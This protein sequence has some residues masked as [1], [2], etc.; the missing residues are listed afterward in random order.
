M[1]SKL[2]LTTALFILFM[3]VS[4]QDLVQTVRGTVVDKISSTPLAGAVVVAVNT[5]PLLGANS[6]MEGQFR[7]ANVPVGIQNFHIS[8]LGYKDVVL[9]EIMVSSGKELVLNVQME[10]DITQS[11]EVVIKADEIKNKPLNAMTSVSARTFSV[12]EAQKF[13]AAVNDPGRMVTSFAGVVSSDDG[14]N[15]VS[16][17]GNSPSGLQWK[18]EGVEIPNPNHYAQAASS[19]GGISILSAQ[20]LANSDFMTGAFAAEYGNA[21]SGVF[22]L[23]LRKGNNEKREYTFQAGLLG[24][25]AAIEGPFSKKGKGSYLV[26]YRYSTLSV[27]QNLGISIGD[28]VTNFQDISFNFH[29]PSEKAGSFSVFG[30]GGLSDQYENASKDTSTW[31]ID[32]KQFN[33]NYYSNT[34][35]IGLKHFI[36]LSD[37]TYIQSAVTLG[38]HN[39]GYKSDKLDEDFTPQFAYNENYLN[40]RLQFTTVL[41]HKLNAKSSFRSGIYY[42]QLMY[43]LGLKFKEEDTGKIVAPI[44]SK[45]S[46]GLLQAFGQ[47]KYR[48]NERLT[49]NAGLHSMFLHSNASKSVEPRLGMRYELDEKQTISFGYGLHSQLLPL[50]LLLSYVD[51]N[52]GQR[53]QPNKNLGFNKAHHFVVA[54]ERNLTKYLYIK[55][56]FYYQ[57]LFNIAI[58]ADSASTLSTVNITDGYIT[59][60]MKSAGR[61]RNYG[62]ELT[63]EQFTHN[64][65]YFLLS[66]S[67]YNSVY[68]AQDKVWRNSRFNGNYATALTAG[69]DMKIGKEAKHKTLGINFRVV[70]VGGF[71]VTPIL[72]DQSIAAGETV[73]DKSRINE[74]KNPDYFRTDIRI[75]LKRNRPKCTTSLALDLMNATNHKNVYGQYFVK[76]SGTIQ[77]SYQV[78]LIPVISY[79]IEF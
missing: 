15:N 24:L 45:G 27:L 61:A 19:G 77:E 59:D 73:Y 34:G 71:R 54:Y 46:V 76:S 28:A 67:L 50:G 57:S 51:N 35:V 62:A 8:L 31:K 33:Q 12:E 23:K 9:Q 39:Q 60:A 75:S 68:Q 53:T 66:A 72:L 13:A 3:N 43:N 14:G 22:D 65:L 58:G 56:E 18:M 47:W 4:A 29:M 37:R 11:T 26:N 69:K 5:N 55:S 79:K 20:L 63:I 41:N 25:N 7:I 74:G 42:S 6:D 16:I 40:S 38:G 21:L 10:E 70:Y 44:D 1:F 48:A 49:I 17:R 36:A 78:P 64:G 2:F 52:N 30:F 32:G